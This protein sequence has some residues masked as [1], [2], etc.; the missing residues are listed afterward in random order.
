MIKEVCKKLNIEYNTQVSHMCLKEFFDYMVIN[1]YNLFSL[2][3]TYYKVLGFS[4]R[5]ADIKANAV[6]E[7]DAL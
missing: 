2:A 5:L 1:G 6:V 4:D 7:G 3:Y